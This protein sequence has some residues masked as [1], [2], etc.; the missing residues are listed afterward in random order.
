MTGI[1][2]ILPVAGELAQLSLAAGRQQF[3]AGTV[4]KLQHHDLASIAAGASDYTADGLSDE[5]LAGSFHGS[6][7]LLLEHSETKP[8]LKT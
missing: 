1:E 3:E 2:P 8:I 4:I 5:V 7:P 6:A